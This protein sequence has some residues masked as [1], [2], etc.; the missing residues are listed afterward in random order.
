MDTS[1]KNSMTFN[2]N[3]RFI[4]AKHLHKYPFPSDVIWSGGAVY[5]CGLFLSYLFR[6]RGAPDPSVP[7]ESTY[8]VLAFPKARPVISAPDAKEAETS[9]KAA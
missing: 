2:S 7:N 4:N 9:L 8:S 3:N 6:Y 1:N 5:L